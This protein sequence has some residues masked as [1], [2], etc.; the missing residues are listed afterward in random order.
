MLKHILSVV[1]LVISSM[2]QYQTKLSNILIAIIIGYLT[3]LISLKLSNHH[4]NRWTMI[5]VFRVDTYYCTLRKPKLLLYVL[6]TCI[7]EELIFRLAFQSFLL[8]FCSNMLLVISLNSAL[9]TI[10]HYKRNQTFDYIKYIDIFILS[11][12]LCVVR[13]VFADIWMC[14]LIHFIHNGLAICRNSQVLY[15]DK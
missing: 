11:M 7:E 12:V 9:F 5:E 4:L 1:A 3:Y 15:F 13:F 8:N 10:C 14:V 2:E 6:I